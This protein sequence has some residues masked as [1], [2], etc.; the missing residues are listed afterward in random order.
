MSPSKQSSFEVTLSQELAVAVSAF[1]LSVLG[2]EIYHQSYDSIYAKKVFL[3]G[4]MER[5]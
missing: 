5:C 4:Q 1:A 3:F 2:A